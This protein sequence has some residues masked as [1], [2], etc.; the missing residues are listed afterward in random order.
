MVVGAVRCGILFVRDGAETDLDP[1][2]IGY[3]S[4][5]DPDA[6]EFTYNSGARRLEVGTV[7]PAP[8][9]GLGEAISVI[10]ELGYGTIEGRIRELTDRLKDG[11]VAADDA[12]LLSPREYESGLVTFAVD[13]PD[14]FVERLSGENI[15]IRS[16]PYPENS[17]RASVHAFNTE[18]DIDALLEHV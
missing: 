1:A 16:L 5:E 15:R 13:D 17:V 6:E 8:Y 18:G 10:E 7:S 3:R 12:R 4:V 2:H 14:G 9:A 11:L